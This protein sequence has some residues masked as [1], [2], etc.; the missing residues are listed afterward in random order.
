ML[1]AMSSINSVSVQFAQNQK[2]F[3]TLKEDIVKKYIFITL[4]GLIGLMYFIPRQLNS[5][6]YDENGDFAHPAS[7]DAYVI[8][9]GFGDDI[10]FAFGRVESWA[11]YKFPMA[12]GLHSAYIDNYSGGL[13]DWPKKLK[14]LRF[15]CDFYSKVYRKEHGITVFED[16]DEWH[17]D[18]Y[19]DSYFS[20]DPNDLP[21]YWWVDY[22]HLDFDL[23]DEA[24]GKY[25]LEADSFLIARF[26]VDG[27]GGR[28]QDDWRAEA[29]LE[30]FEHGE[31]NLGIDD[32]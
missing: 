10:G 15:Y 17:D 4:I 18:G 28:E 20:N 3:N 25:T 19:L 2:M 14:G 24:W 7:G 32:W 26:N 16:S 5:H 8:D 23:T 30:K 9:E 21:G 11:H 22:K 31:E 1:L 13:P 6:I 12:T 27:E 29:I